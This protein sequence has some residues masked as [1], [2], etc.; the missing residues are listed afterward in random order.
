MVCW[1]VAIGLA[2]LGFVLG[3]IFAAMLITPTAVRLSPRSPDW[4]Q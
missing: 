1:A 3:A 2:A 4:E